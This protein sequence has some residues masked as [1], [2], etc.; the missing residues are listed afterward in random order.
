IGRDARACRPVRSARLGV[1]LV[2][3]L[4]AA[5]YVTA[6]TYSRDRRRT[7]RARPGSPRRQL[8]AG[9]RVV[10]STPSSHRPQLPTTNSERADGVGGKS[11]R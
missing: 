8:V 11:D 5:L 6:V 7:R 9:R 3:V 4:V 2:L 10:P 1:L